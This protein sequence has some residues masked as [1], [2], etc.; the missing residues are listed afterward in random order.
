MGYSRQV[1]E[2]VQS[3]YENKRADAEKKLAERQM[4]MY[5]KC[6]VLRQI[7]TA[8]SATGLK[9]YKAALEGKDGLDE[10]IDKI[11]KEVLEL[12]DDKRRIL[13]MSEKPENYLDIVYSCK[14]CS[15]TGYAGLKMCSC[16]KK[17][18]V[19]EA[20]QTSG[21]G[22]VLDKQDFD[23]FN[24]ELY[25]DKKGSNG[26]SP[27]DM[28]TYVLKSAKEYVKNFGKQDKNENLLFIGKTGLGKTHISTA[29]AKGVID[30]GYDVVYDTITNI[31]NTFEQQTFAHSSE[32][33]ANA[34]RYNECALLIIDDLGTEFKNT[35][36]QSMLYSLLNNRIISG[37]A[38]IISTNLDDSE[39][40]KKQYDDRINSRL[41]GNFR[42]FKFAGED[43][44]IKNA[45][46]NSKKKSK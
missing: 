37:K 25:S 28:M 26:T 29:I 22:A 30:K 21:L 4:E 39:L 32:A 3:E 36:T 6:P 31:I 33:A 14:K 17:A 19:K 10:R 40:F 11:K 34:E 41:I 1:I 43:I 42:S 12:Q 13:K 7:D 2:K 8:L 45:V 18:L 9:I 38:M 35:Y 5:E 44:R 24:L 23:N 20:Y 15:D 27:R 46:S 16:M